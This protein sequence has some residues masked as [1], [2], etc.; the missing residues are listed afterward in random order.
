[1][2]YLTHT[3]ALLC[4]C[5]AFA[6]SGS[7]AIVADTSANRQEAKADY[8]YL[9]AA[10]ARGND[11]PDSYFE[12]V[13]HAYALNPDD[14]YLGFEH[15]YN[16]V[17]LSRGDSAA[18]AEGYKLMGRYV[19]DNPD[20]FYNNVV[21]AAISSQIGQDSNAIAIW[22]RLHRNHPS[23][24]ELTARYAEVLGGSGDSLNI[25]KAIE[26]YDSLEA[27]QGAGMQLTSRKIQLYY[28]DADTS[29]MLNEVR[30]LVRQS[31]ANP[32]YNIFAGDIYFQLNSR[33]SALMFYNKAVELDPSIGLAY[34]SRASFFRATGDS[35]SYD[36][37]IFRALEEESLEVE[38]KIEI[39]R[40]YTAGLYNDTLQRPKIDKM[41]RRL[42]EIHPHEAAI[43]N[44]YR[45]YLIAI[46][47]YPA[48]AE[49]A[50]YSLDINPSDERQWLALTSLYMRSSKFDKALES[51]LR[52]EHFYP[53]NATLYLLASA[54]LTQMKDYDRAM[55]QL[56]KGL[57][58]ADSTD[59][60]IRSELLTAVGDILYAREELDSAF[61]YYNK[62]LELDPENMTALN[63]CAYYLA[64][65]DRD[66][67]KAEDMILR[68]VA[69]RPD[70]PTSLDTYAWVLFKKKEY[71]RAL[72]VIDTAIANSPEPSADLFDHAGDIAFMNQDYDRA[73]AEW[74]KALELDPQNE[75]IAKKV[76]HKTY[77]AK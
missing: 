51:A 52:A 40:D 24:P 4:V 36:R 74:R 33:D 21:Y 72:E 22:G 16:L 38:P 61:S 59:Y 37:D 31:P 71:E 49:Q 39:L 77:F 7:R 12:L 5:L 14:E 69:E 27:S 26:L 20:D 35:L 63:N 50:Q 25:A 13:R 48:A 23:R 1:M 62:A 43:H 76:K 17:R 58:V 60:E 68:V 70:E 30:N 32:D 56:T 19:T 67:D 73:V 18:L 2:R 65:S 54:N 64:C 3:L 75:L 8:V 42:I 53:D 11:R 9:E 34:Y 28:M 29:A 46:E 15:G 44:L 45:D 41:Y 55:N 47:N 57:Q 6:C 66:L 10:K